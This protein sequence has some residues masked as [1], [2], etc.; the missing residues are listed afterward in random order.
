M[1]L[2]EVE[3]V[4]GDGATSLFPLDYLAAFV[5]S[6]KTQS[7]VVQLGTDYP[8]RMD[9]DG[10]TKGTYLCGPRIETPA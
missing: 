2:R 9:W 7:L 10:A 5:K 1:E 6:V 4:R 3:Y 8:I